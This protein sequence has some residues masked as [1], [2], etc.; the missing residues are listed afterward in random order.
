MNNSAGGGGRWAVYHFG[1]RSTKVRNQISPTGKHCGRHHKLN[2]KN[3]I[4]FPPKFLK[5]MIY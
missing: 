1:D 2:K 4:S 3:T 5:G